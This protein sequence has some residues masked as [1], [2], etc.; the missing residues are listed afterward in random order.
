[1]ICPLITIVPDISFEDTARLLK[2]RGG[3]LQTNGKVALI[4]PTLLRGYAKCAGAGK[5]KAA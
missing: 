5:K 1:M 4:A 2:E 3:I